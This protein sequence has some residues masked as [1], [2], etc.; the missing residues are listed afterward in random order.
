MVR[1]DPDGRRLVYGLL[2]PAGRKVKLAVSG[3]SVTWTFPRGEVDTT[4]GVLALP[5]WSTTCYVSARTTSTVTITFGTA[6]GV[7]DT[8]DILIFRE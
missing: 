6:A 8:V 7:S 5:T 4:Y 1:D 2:T 3:T